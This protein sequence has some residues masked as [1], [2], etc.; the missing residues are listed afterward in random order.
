MKL[1][2]RHIAARLYDRLWLAPRGFGNPPPVEVWDRDFAAGRWAFLADVSESARYALIHNYAVR[3]ASGPYSVLDVGSGTGVMRTFFA[4]G[5]L[6]DYTGLDISKE[7]VRLSSEHGYPKSRFLV[8]DFD[9]YTPD[10]PHNVIIFNETLTYAKDPGV[11][12]RKYWAGLPQGGVCVVSICDYDARNRAN[13]SRFE[14]DHKPDF[15]S[16]LVNE[17][18]QAW[19]IKAYIQRY[20]R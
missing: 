11:T 16:R 17:K 6:E 3:C 18:G 9:A 10:Q 7:A 15:S 19:D 2:P 14:N 5:D 13:W 1:S 20:R 4:D 8:A 12:F